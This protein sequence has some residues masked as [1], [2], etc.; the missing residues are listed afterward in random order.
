MEKENEIL[1]G[2]VYVRKERVKWLH[3]KRYIVAHSKGGSNP[4]EGNQARLIIYKYKSQSDNLEV[5]R[6]I[7]FGVV[8]GIYGGPSGITLR[9]RDKDFKFRSKRSSVNKQWMEVCWLL[10]AIP[11]HA[12]PK[13]PDADR[14]QLRPELAELSKQYSELYNAHDAW[15]VQI[16]QSTIAVSLKVTGLRIITISKEGT[17]NI[18]FPSNDGTQTKFSSDEIRRC[19]L[20]KS[21]VFV[22]IGSLSTGGAKG[23]IWMDCF[24][25]RVKEIRDKIH[26]FL[27]YGP[28][29]SLPAMYCPNFLADMPFSPWCLCDQPTPYR[30]RSTS[31][32]SQS[33][34][35]SDMPVPLPAPRPFVDL[36][37]H[38][39][40]KKSAGTSTS[41][42]RGHAAQRVERR[43][44]SLKEEYDDDYEIARR[45]KRKSILLAEGYSTPVSHTS[46]ARR[47]P[48]AIARTPS[49]VCSNGDDRSILPD[50]LKLHS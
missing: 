9:L 1:S 45:R 43:S 36:S 8:L 12:I 4:I 14:S 33:S 16:L 38:P 28:E 47:A 2:F 27:F 22:E 48:D 49:K 23:I 29:A 32:C 10:N 21:M 42:P 46:T 13:P 20:W 37:T 11:N 30:S 18:I 19:G 40:I 41:S 44:L 6:Q 31:V 50:Y 3:K 17:L 7:N 35:N 39:V 26:N 25:D 5:L 15:A 34:G 24:K